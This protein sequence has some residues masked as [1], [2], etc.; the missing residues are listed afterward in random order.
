M[1]GLSYYLAIKAEALH[2]TDRT[3]EALEAIREA[4]AL[5]ERSEERW[6]SAELKRLRGVLLAALDADEAQ[7]EASFGE[8]IRTARQQKSIS[9]RK[10]AEASLAEYRGR[11]GRPR[12]A[13]GDPTQ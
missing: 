12:K 2:L 6:S 7:V 11:K 4:E 13:R 10:R 8:A 5:V 9:L 3:S 1:L